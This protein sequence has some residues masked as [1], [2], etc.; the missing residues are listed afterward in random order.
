MHQD[1]KRYSYFLDFLNI[2][3]H[4][5]NCLHLT[6]STCMNGPSSSR[7]SAVSVATTSVLILDESPIL[8]VLVSQV[9]NYIYTGTIEEIQSFENV[10]QSEFQVGELKRKISM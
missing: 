5:R 3:D 1:H 6:V 4:I 10:L 2:F 8:F 7:I 9:D